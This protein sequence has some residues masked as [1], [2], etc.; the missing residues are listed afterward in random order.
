MRPILVAVTALF[1]AYTAWVV[2]HTGFVGFFEQLL[3]SQAGWQVLVDIVIAL[4]LVLS[5]IRRDARAHARPF[6]PYAFLTLFLGSIGPLVY[7]VLR[8]SPSRAWPEGT[9]VPPPF[10]EAQNR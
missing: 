2:S 6:W 3:A 5:W 4:F 10:P 8:P 1:S 7:L 9:V